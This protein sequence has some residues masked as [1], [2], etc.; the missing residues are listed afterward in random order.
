MSGYTTM[1]ERRP[2]TMRPGSVGA[3]VY[4]GRLGSIAIIFGTP[5]GNAKP[6]ELLDAVEVIGRRMTAHEWHGMDSFRSSSIVRAMRN[7]EALGDRAR[8]MQ[9]YLELHGDAGYIMTDLHAIQDVT[10]SRMLA[11]VDQFLDVSRA[12]FVV[13]TL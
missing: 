5:V 11:A 10:S 4:T 1:N 3:D 6:D 8:Q 9:D 12:A 7:M 2:Q 13:V